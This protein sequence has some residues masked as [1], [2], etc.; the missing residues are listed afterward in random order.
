MEVIKRHVCKTGS[1]GR[2]PPRDCYCATQRRTA[3]TKAV[4]INASVPSSSG[5]GGVSVLSLWRSGALL[6]LINRSVMYSRMRWQ[7][8]GWHIYRASRGGAFLLVAHGS[9]FIGCSLKSSTAPPSASTVWLITSP[10]TTI[11]T[12]VSAPVA[13][14]TT[15]SIEPGNICSLRC[16]LYESTTE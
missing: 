6:W 10:S 9:T 8:H 4:V 1:K 5:E 3:K 12:A 7:V 11:T 16:H 2:E 15:T 13:A 14:T